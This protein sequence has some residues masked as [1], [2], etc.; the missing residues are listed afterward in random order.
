MHHEDSLTPVATRQLLRCHRCGRT[1]EITHSDVMQFMGKGWPA[2]C[3]EVMAY[4]LESKRP[5]H[6][7]VGDPPTVY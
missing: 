2:C 1:G 4:Y 7:E 5:S 3:G 6:R